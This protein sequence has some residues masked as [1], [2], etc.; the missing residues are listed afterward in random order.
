V[1]KLKAR[2]ANT[3]LS[4][5]HYNAVQ[6]ARDVDEPPWRGSVVQAT[7]AAGMVAATAI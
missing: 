5:E 1:A 7:I 2:F 6:V 4:S 3:S